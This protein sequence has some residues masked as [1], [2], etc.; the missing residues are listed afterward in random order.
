MKASPD[1]EMDDVLEKLTRRGRDCEVVDQ[2][3]FSSMR[4]IPPPISVLRVVPYLIIYFNI[5]AKIDRLEISYFLT[6]QQ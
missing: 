1:A 5:P 6:Q 4:R 2:W 3:Y